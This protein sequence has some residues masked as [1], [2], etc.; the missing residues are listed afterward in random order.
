MTSSSGLARPP[1]AWMWP[2]RGIRSTRA[3]QR[4]R[5]WASQDQL[6]AWRA[7]AHAPDT[8]IAFIGGEMMLYVVADVRPPFT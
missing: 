5:A 3:G 4:L 6:D 7:V 1:G 2:S 8:G